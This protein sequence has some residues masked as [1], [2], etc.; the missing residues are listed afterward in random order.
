MFDCHFQFITPA[1]LDP[2]PRILPVERLSA[3]LEVSVGVDRHLTG[4]E[5]VLPLDPSGPLF[6]ELGEYIM[7]LVS[8]LFVKPRASFV[9]VNAV[10]P[11]H[12]RWTSTHEP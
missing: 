5:M 2:L 10:F 11:T 4:S 9:E 6:V 8:V 7:I 12:H 1:C 3:S